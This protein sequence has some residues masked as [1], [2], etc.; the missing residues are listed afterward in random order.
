MDKGTSCQSDRE[1]LCFTMKIC[2]RQSQ[3]IRLVTNSEN[4]QGEVSKEAHKLERSDNDL[5]GIWMEHCLSG[6][7]YYMKMQKHW[8]ILF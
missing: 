5:Q 1:R 8:A 4:V 3:K 6:T 2:A 7:K